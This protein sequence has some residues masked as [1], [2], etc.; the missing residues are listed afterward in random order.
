MEREL[1]AIIKKLKEKYNTLENEYLVECQKD[2]MSRRATY[3]DGGLAVL[4]EVI[5]LLEDENSD[6]VVDA[7]VD[8]MFE[9]EQ[10]DTYEYDEIGYN[11]Y[12]GGY[13]EDL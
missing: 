12:T 8:S 2:F 3:L 4:N 10:E 6:E 5:E 11:P 9:E 7:L 1:N 13:D